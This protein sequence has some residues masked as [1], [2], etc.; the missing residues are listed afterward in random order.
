MFQSLF[1]NSYT[2]NDPATRARSFKAWL[3]RVCEISQNQNLFVDNLSEEIAA[4]IQED[5]KLDAK[6]KASEARKRKADEKKTAVA[7]AQS[8][9]LV[10]PAPVLAQNLPSRS[11][12]AAAAPVEQVPDSGSSSDFVDLSNDDNLNTAVQ[13]R[14]TN[15]RPTIGN[16]RMLTEN[17]NEQSRLFHDVD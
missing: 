2:S 17:R 16:G 11:N 9:M 10:T 3:K 8:R 15:R 5:A 7:A 4:F 6:N 12:T 13:A 1:L 14:I